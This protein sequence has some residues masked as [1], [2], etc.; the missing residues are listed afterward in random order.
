MFKKIKKNIPPLMLL[1]AV[2]VALACPL[3]A[4]EEETIDELMSG[5]D[6]Q[7]AESPDTDLDGFDN[8]EGVDRIGEA[9][10]HQPKFARFFLVLV[11]FL[12]VWAIL[13]TGSPL[14]LPSKEE[15]DEALLLISTKSNKSQ[16]NGEVLFID[17]RQLLTFGYIK[18]VR[19][20]PDYEKKY[21][22]DRAMAGNATYFQTFYRD[23]A[24]Q[25]FALIISE[26][27][28]LNRQGTSDGFQDENNAWVQWVSEP[29]L[30]YYSPI[31][32]LPEV[33]VQLLVPKQEPSECP[34][35]Y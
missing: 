10:H 2:I 28:Y 27:L 7:E 35:P 19:L 16:K 12:P 21:L 31:A 18:D 30:C 8:Q 5:F 23:L 15:I 34:S 14:D 24:N 4:Q 11:L 17:Q 29:L 1:L 26:P 20:V 13:Q 25:R 33:R 32:T 9:F 6:D 3:Y 22:M